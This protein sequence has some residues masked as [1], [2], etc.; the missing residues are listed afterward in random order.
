MEKNMQEVNHNLGN[1]LSLIKYPLI[2]EK[3][4]N[5]FENR[6]YTFIV[7]RCLTKSE[8]KY[9]LEKIF[10][11]KIIGVSIMNL[12]QKYKKVGKFIGKRS[13]YKKVIIKL[14]EGD[15]IKNIFD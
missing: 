13:S 11:I 14:K 5:L 10:T 9:T 3:S 6:Q 8:I 12:P 4:F 15:S 1:I 7:D 2:T